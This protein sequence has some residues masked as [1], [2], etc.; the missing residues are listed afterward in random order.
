MAD[1][2]IETQRTWSAAYHTGLADAA[3]AFGQAISEAVGGDLSDDQA[4]IIRRLVDG[5]DRPAARAPGESPAPRPDDWP[6]T[7]QMTPDERRA[8]YAALVGSWDATS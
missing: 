7:E 6:G 8:V 5:W 4:A 2:S 1:L 3:Y